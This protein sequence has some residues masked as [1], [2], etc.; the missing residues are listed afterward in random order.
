[1]TQRVG[2]GSRANSSKV[3]ITSNRFFLEGLYSPA[4]I[5][6]TA[7]IASHVEKQAR[8]V[9]ENY[10]R[11]STYLRLFGSI[12]QKQANRYLRAQIRRKSIKAPNV[13]RKTK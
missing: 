3:G 11:H 6:Y 1:M 10:V 2:G 12:R 7:V 8:I 4:K 9:L 5:H 13:E